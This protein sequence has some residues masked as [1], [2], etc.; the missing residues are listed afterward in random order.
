MQSGPFSTTK[1]RQRVN[2][3]R[4]NT[5]GR[6]NPIS[7]E[8]CTNSLNDI[9]LFKDKAKRRLKDGISTWN[10]KHEPQ[11]AADLVV[12]PKKVEEVKTWLLN[13]FRENNQNCDR[14]PA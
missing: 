3:T 7:L 2:G 14:S 1:K 13:A 11:K 6:P 5:A 9:D 8:G 12:H 10:T 4:K